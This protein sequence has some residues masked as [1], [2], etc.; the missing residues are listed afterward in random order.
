MTAGLASNWF[1]CGARSR[2]FQPFCT[3]NAV[4][5]IAFGG[6]A[7]PRFPHFFTHT[8]TSNVCACLHYR[9]GFGGGVQ[10]F[11]RVCGKT[12]FRVN[13]FKKETTAD[14]CT[15]A[16]ARTIS[17]NVRHLAVCF[18]CRCPPSIKRR[19]PNR[20]ERRPCC[21]EVASQRRLRVEN[22]CPC[23]DV[24]AVTLC[25]VT[26]TRL[27]RVLMQRDAA[28]AAHLMEKPRLALSVELMPL[29]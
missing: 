1:S 29:R 7:S 19:V 28:Y 24:A 17:T 11:A 27:A 20:R 14:F 26:A 6:T 5:P 21:T 18:H 22:P 25:H 4:P 16:A 8:K 10:S 13:P 23:V 2:L 15:N 3:C 12:K 9:P